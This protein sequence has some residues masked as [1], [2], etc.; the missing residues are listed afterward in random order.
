MARYQDIALQLGEA[1]ERLVYRPG[2]RLPSIR[3]ASRAHSVLIRSMETA[4]PPACRTTRPQGG[5]L[6]WVQLPERVDALRLHALVQQK[7]I[8]LAPG[9]LFSAQRNYRRFVRL[10]F[11]V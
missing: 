3:E 2:E 11:G 4:F 9:P 1:I 8:S 10:N 6:L 5:Y 7:Q